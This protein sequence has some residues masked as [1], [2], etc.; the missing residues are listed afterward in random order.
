MAPTS[1]ATHQGETTPAAVSPWCIA[2]PATVKA[3]NDQ[4][5]RRANRSASAL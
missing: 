3:N 1:T 2:F 5:R 4:V